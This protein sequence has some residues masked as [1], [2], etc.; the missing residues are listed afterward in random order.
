MPSVPPTASPMTARWRPRQSRWAARAMPMSSRQG[1]RVRRQQ[2]S[3][4]LTWLIGSRQTWWSS[5][6]H[7]VRTPNRFAD[8]GALAAQAVKL[9]GPVYAYVEQAGRK[10]TQAE[11]LNA[12]DTGYRIEPMKNVSLDV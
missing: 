8:D 5:A 10:G 6:S 3:A 2:S 9:G 12:Y 1:A 11:V 7:S 4:L